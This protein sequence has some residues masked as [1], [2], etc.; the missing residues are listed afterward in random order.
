MVHDTRRRVGENRPGD[1]IRRLAHFELNLSNA[2]LV[3]AQLQVLALIT[4]QAIASLRQD[5]HLH[6]IAEMIREAFRQ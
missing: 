1:D 3:R 5:A 2:R 4:Q 6:W